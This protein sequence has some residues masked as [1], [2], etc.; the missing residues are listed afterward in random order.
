VETCYL[1]TGQP[2]VCT[3][4]VGSPCDDGDLCTN[5]DVCGAG[6]TCVGEDKPRAD[7]REP[8]VPGKALL[9]IKNSSNPNSR[10]ILF[11]W[12]KGAA[13]ST[14]D[15][16]NPAFGTTDYSLCVYDEEGDVPARIFKV[17]AP[18]QSFCSGD[19]CWKSTSSGY[20][21]KDRDGSRGG[22]QQIQL[23]AGPGGKAKAQ[24][25]VRGPN[26]V[27]PSLGLS[28]DTT[29]TAQLVGK[30]AACFEA[31]FSAPARVN[32][33]EQFRDKGN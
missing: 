31:E 9:R 13:T 6:G 16:G 19:L 18:A 4:S 23:K 30:N 32:S 33:S 5:D 17:T 12:I 2:S 21:Y 25:R 10:Q 7:C 8:A 29:V 22:L 14:N 26:L 27:L 11:K 1:C 3:P 20:S 24:A 28:Q 15:F